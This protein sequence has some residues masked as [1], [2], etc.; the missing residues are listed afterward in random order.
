MR[1]ISNR[2]AALLLS[3]CI[4][5]V[6]LQ[7]DVSPKPTPRPRVSRFGGVFYPK[8]YVEYYE[9][10]Q[11]QLGEAT[12]DRSILNG[13]VLALVEAVVPKPKSTKLR[14]PKGDPDNYAKGPL[15][16]AQKVGV[17]NDDIQVQ[18]LASIKRWAEPGEIPHLNVTFGVLPD[19]ALTE[20]D[21]A[22]A[23]ST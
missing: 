16:A 7:L 5:S 17:L 18:L 8:P 3:L 2:L 10:L 22:Q 20:G 6:S 19:E 15:D 12:W 4:D 11:V 21:G 14:Y 9:E 1:R 13:P 23:P